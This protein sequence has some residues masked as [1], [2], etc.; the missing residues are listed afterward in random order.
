MSAAVQRRTR[1]A[2]LDAARQTPRRGFQVR[3]HVRPSVGWQRDLFDQIVSILM[4][5]VKR[6]VARD[7]AIPSTTGRWR[8]TR[9]AA[10][11]FSEDMFPWR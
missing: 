11:P 10:D 1:N 7:A 5:V 4:N 8:G 6:A 2:R 9:T 3:D